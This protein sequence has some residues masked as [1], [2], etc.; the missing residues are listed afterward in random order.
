MRA[1]CSGRAGSD[2]NV[3][4]LG[5]AVSW[6]DRTQGDFR[7]SLPYIKLTWLQKSASS[8]LGLHNSP[9]ADNCREVISLRIGPGP[10]AHLSK[11]DCPR[12]FEYRTIRSEMGSL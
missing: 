7:R 4:R 10:R 11:C 2:F 8:C 3:S 5:R 12:T 1:A 6:V 9:D